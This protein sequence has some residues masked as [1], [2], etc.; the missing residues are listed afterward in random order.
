MSKLLGRWF[1]I[2]EGEAGLFLW[3][4]LLRILLLSGII[5]ITNYADTAFLARYGVE[6]LP[7]MYFIN[8]FAGIMAMAVLTG[9]MVKMPGAR[10]LSYMFLFFGV[11]T[12]II[13]FLIPTGFDLLYPILWIIKAQ[14]EAITGLLF[15]NLANDLFNIRQSK[16]LFSL[17]YAGGYAGYIFFSFSMPFISKIIGFDNLL[18]VYV[19]IS[20]LAALVVKHMGTIFPT[21]LVSDKKTGKKKKPKKGMKDQVKEAMPLIRSSLLIKIL[22]V[23]FILPTA[24]LTV[25]NFQFNFVVDDYFT[26]PSAKLQFFGYFRGVMGIV[27]LIVLLFVSRIY[28]RWGLPV[29]LMFHPANYIVAFSALLFNFSW[30]P[31]MY[32]RMS[33]QVLSKTIFIPARSVVMGLLPESQRAIMMPVLRG[34]LPKA[35][36]L[37]G[38]ILL[39]VLGNL[40]HARYLSLFI[41]PFVVVWLIAPIV[42][43]RNYSKIL[44]DLISK[45]MLDLKSM[46]KDDMEEL[47]RDKV[48]REQLIKTFCSTQGSECLWYAGLLKSLAVE[49]LDANILRMLKGQDDQTRIGLLALLSSA[50][51]TEAVEVFSELVD[52]QNPTLMA[53]IITA[54]NRLDL[55]YSP[56]LNREAFEKARI[57]EV[58]ALALAGLFRGDPDKYTK[59]IEAWLHSTVKEE[60]LAG[61]IAAGASGEKG[62][63]DTLKRLLA[64]KEN[65]PMDDRI[66]ESLHR[67]EAPDIN[68]LVEPF[69]N[70]ARATVRRSALAA[71]D[72]HDEIWLR[73]AV[74]MLGDIS[75]EIH[76]LAKEKIKTAEY[77]NGQVLIESLN[78]PRRMIREGVFDLLEALK[79]GDIDAYRFA[80]TQLGEGYNYL[81]A[82][83]Y[84]ASFPASEARNLLLDHLEQKSRLELEN[85]LRVLA[86]QDKSGQMKIISRGIFSADSLQRANSMEALDDL[87]DRSLSKILLP[88]L[89]AAPLSD[90]LAVGRKNFKLPLFGE[91]KENFLTWLTEKHK[92]LSLMLLLNL[93]AHEGPDKGDITAI[94]ELEISAE[95]VVRKSARQTLIKSGQYPLEKENVM[96]TE[97]VITD[98]ILLLKKIEMFEGLTV[99]EL[100]AV[101]SVTE[102]VQFQPGEVVI[103]RGEMGETMYLLIK[104]EVSVHIGDTS[105]NEIEVDRIKA[106]DY[107]GE[108]ALFEDVPRSATIR[109]ETESR[110]LV[111]H[112]QEFNEIVREYPQIALTICKVLSSRIRTLHEKI[113]QGS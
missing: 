85:V 71:L 1:K 14:A 12:A 18:L 26:T 65:Q 68:A 111:L 22:V 86:L 46:E 10:L 61:V 52:H 11:I 27:N 107:F 58:R 23:L 89:G 36:G 101:G 57:P 55:A 105:G 28:G 78:I 84:I 74:A 109:T 17:I 15:L 90:K 67:L 82:I 80:R 16:R 56:Q 103:K 99:S 32:A 37:L 43:K 69:L 92:R 112:K 91:G 102:E 51:E 3:T 73:R 62:F 106:G 39:I 21:L 31:G 47:F 60:R 95:D 50:P 24:V 49:E 53:A 7:L 33:T 8:P 100:A 30:I 29:A 9:F 79:I 64:E 108:M 25:M 13:R 72:I 54:A 41:L 44:L 83:N 19:V 94:K 81:A 75:E 59:Q 40:F 104:G 87:L 66:I 34:V 97:V 48:I 63:V 4:V 113:K 77:Q 93:L 88:L 96:A 98:K 6:K 35:G 38:S 20:I 70:H 42:M 110:L 45:K 2:Y 76:D 5:I